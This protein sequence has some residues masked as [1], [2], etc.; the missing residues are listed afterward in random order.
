MRIVQKRMPG[1]RLG[2]YAAGL[3]LLLLAV[4]GAAGCA[5]STAPSSVSLTMA[6]N[7]RTVTVQPGGKVLLTLAENQTTGYSWAIAQIDE[8]VLGL[9]SSTYTIFTASPSVVGEGG[10]HTFTFT[11]KQAGT[12]PLAL[13]ECYPWACASSIIAHF[14]VTIQVM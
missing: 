4:L 5:Q 12:S 10:I 1:R 6:D 2:V 11:A 14:A 9:T 7:G 3:A 8:T 13:R